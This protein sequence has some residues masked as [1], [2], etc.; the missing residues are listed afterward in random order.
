MARAVGQMEGA[1]QR[2][3]AMVAYEAVSVRGA[4]RAAAMAEM[5]DKMERLVRVAWTVTVVDS[6]TKV[7]WKVALMV[8]VA[9][10]AAMADWAALEGG[11][12]AQSRDHCRSWLMHW[13]RR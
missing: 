11:N 12:L 5:V 6:T 7:A 2:A 13:V 9:P 4:V 3:E 1:G 10:S 8:V